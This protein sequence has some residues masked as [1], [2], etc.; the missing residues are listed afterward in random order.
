[1]VEQFGG[2]VT[3]S[4]VRQHGHD[5]LSGVLWTRRH[6]SGSSEGGTSGDADDAL[7][8]HHLAGYR[9][10]L[11]TRNVDRLVDEVGAQDGRQC[12]SPGDALDLVRDELTT[13]EDGRLG[14]TA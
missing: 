10:R 6:H 8:A 12:G 1:M 9:N 5:H 3:L 4:G 2:G 11:L 7:G 14:S 13:V